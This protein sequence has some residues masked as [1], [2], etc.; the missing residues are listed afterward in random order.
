MQGDHRVRHCSECNLN[1]YNFSATPEREIQEL[2]LAKN[3]RLCARWFRR[4]DGTILTADCPVG[5]RARVRKISLAAGS[6]LS[7]L[8]ILSP[9]A[10]Q[11][12]DKTLDSTAKIENSDIGSGVEPNKKLGTTLQSALGMSSEMG[13]V[14]PVGNRLKFRVRR[15]T[16]FFLPLPLPPAQDTAPIQKTPIRSVFQKPKDNSK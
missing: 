12:S 4:S 8:L 3:E 5:F 14:V 11:T 10:A 7:A 13:W 16:P 6:A 1:V 9:A 2:L 15:A